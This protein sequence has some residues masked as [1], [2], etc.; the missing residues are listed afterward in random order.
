MIDLPEEFLGLHGTYQLPPA[1]PPPKLPPPPLNP[2]PPPPRAAAEAAPRTVRPIAGTAVDD[3]AGS[4]K[5]SQKHEQDDEGDDEPGLHSRLRLLCPRGGGPA[6]AFVLAFGGRDNRVDA[7]RH[8]AVKIALLQPGRDLGVDDLLGRR[9]RQRTFKAVAN[10]DEQLVIL[11]EDEQDDSVVPRLLACLPGL[12]QA[13]G[14]ILDR[15]IR[16]HL[17]IDGDEELVGGLAFKLGQ[18]QLRRSAASL[19]TTPA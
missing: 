10:L 11:R 14:V 18:A 6:G 17:G 3:P 15:G 5:E 9:I 2:P 8:A 4:T 12:G 19:E 1:P 7:G 16:L 13:D